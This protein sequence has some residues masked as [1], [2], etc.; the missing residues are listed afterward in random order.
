MAS[1]SSGI[2]CLLYSLYLLERIYYI[3]QRSK[4]SLSQQRRST[5]MTA[6]ISKI[7]TTYIKNGGFPGLVF[8]TVFFVVFKCSVSSTLFLLFQHTGMTLFQINNLEKIF[9]FD[10]IRLFMIIIDCLEC[11]FP[12][13][14]F[15]CI[16]YTVNL[17]NKRC[18]VD[19]TIRQ[20][21]VI[22]IRHVPY[23]KFTSNNSI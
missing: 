9:L 23:L 4:I 15:L 14:T 16:V 11:Q 12:V 1:S 13:T 3:E 22:C 6:K 19:K 2:K 18:S 20:Q 17:I 8:P 21:Q 7:C 5:K 10:I